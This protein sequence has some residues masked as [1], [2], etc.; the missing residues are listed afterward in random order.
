MQELEIRSMKCPKQNSS[1]ISTNTKNMFNRYKITDSEFA[2]LQEQFGKLTHYQSWDLLRK[3]AQNNIGDD[4]EDIVQT[5]NMALLF[6]GVYHKRQTYIEKCFAICEEYCLDEVA[7]LTLKHLKFLWKR[8]NR[9]GA[10]KQK[11]GELQE[12]ILEKLTQKHVP[13]DKLPDLNAPLVITKQFRVYCK[14]ILWNSIKNLG[15]KITRDR[16]LRNGSVSLSSFDYLS[17]VL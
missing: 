3:N 9:H 6:A 11:F 5:L 16:P 2:E 17:D 14:N 15:K 13:T 12:E 8:K 4:Q 7:N 1:G 10:N